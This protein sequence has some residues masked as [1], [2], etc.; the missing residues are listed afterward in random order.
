MSVSVPAAP[1]RPEALLALRSVLCVSA[2]Q[3]SRKRSLLERNGWN[4]AGT[5]ETKERL[6]EMR[7]TSQRVNTVYETEAADTPAVLTFIKRS[8]GGKMPRQRDSRIQPRK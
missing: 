8:L 4:F 1:A 6:K 7:K 5:A 3:R 2:V